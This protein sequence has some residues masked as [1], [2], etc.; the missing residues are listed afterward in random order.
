M[1]EYL[2][3]TVFL[4]PLLQ[5]LY[6]E[7]R[8]GCPT[9]TAATTTT[10]GQTTEQSENANVFRYSAYEAIIDIYI[11]DVVLSLF[12]LCLPRITVVVVG[13]RAFAHAI[14]SKQST[15]MP[16]LLLRYFMQIIVLVVAICRHLFLTACLIC[17]CDA[18]RV[19][20]HPGCMPIMRKKR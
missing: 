6:Q 4:L 7:T 2:W 13:E 20:L 16:V 11:C 10:T 9:A 1:S 12:V 19:Y 8:N 18:N 14:H 17:M 15:G 5:S 3:R